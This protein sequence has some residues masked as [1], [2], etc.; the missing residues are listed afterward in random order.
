M[1]VCIYTHTCMHSPAPKVLNSLAWTP[2]RW[3]RQGCRPQ[4][5]PEETYAQASKVKGSYKDSEKGSY[6][7]SSKGS[8]TGSYKGS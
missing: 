8:C 3:P 5:P 1:Y 6:K 2:A 4:R 7:G